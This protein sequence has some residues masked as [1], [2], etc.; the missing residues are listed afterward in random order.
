MLTLEK[1]IDTIK[2]PDSE[3][4]SLAKRR[5][6]S[7]AKPLNSLGVLERDLIRIAGVKGTPRFSIGRKA[8][9][10]MCADN[11]IVAEGVTQTGREVTAIV[12]EHMGEGTS[13]VCRMAAVAGA[14]VIPVDIGIAGEVS[15]PGILRMKVAPGTRNFLKEAAMSRRETVQALETGIAVAGE[16]SRRGF[17]MLGS[18][19]MGI[20]NTTTSSAVLSVLLEQP[21]GRVTGRGAGLDTPSLHRKIAVIEEGIRLRCPDKR[22]G[23]DVLSKVGGLDLAGLAGLYIGCAYYGIPA[24]LDGLICAAAALAAVRI[25]PAVGGYLLA[26]HVSAEPAGAMALEALGLEPA[27]NAGM[28]LGEGTGAAALFPLLDMALAVYDGMS[29]FGEMQVEQYQPLT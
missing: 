25:C 3:A 13:C 29:T 11:G 16:M 15:S 9:V 19:E 7:V 12:A 26:S 24:V 1:V 10:V 6:D 4:A 27:I 5:W 18:G 22:D 21:A 28:C 8:I 14:Q 20:G 2:E 17:E 23:I